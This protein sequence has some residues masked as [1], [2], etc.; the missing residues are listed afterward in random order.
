VPLDRGCLAHASRA[1]R[2]ARPDDAQVER[3]WT[4][5]SSASG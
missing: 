3:A 1:A 4:A 5:C 2:A